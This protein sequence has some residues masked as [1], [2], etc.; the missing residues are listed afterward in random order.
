MYVNIYS[1]K[2]QLTINTPFVQNQINTKKKKLNMLTVRL[3]I[4]ILT[5]IKQNKISVK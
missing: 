2:Y 1:L 5:C 4:K 3:V